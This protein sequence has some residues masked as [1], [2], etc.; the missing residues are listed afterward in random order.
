MIIV[1]AV[2]MGQEGTLKV[3][4]WTLDPD[5]TISRNI[6][7][8]IAYYVPERK[9]NFCHVLATGILGFSIISSQT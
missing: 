8:G 3:E 2:S 5:D 6:R 9:I 7:P 4:S 1:P